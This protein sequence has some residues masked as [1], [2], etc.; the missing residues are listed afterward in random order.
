MEKIKRINFEKS[1]LNINP[2]F[3]G[4]ENRKRTC[5]LPKKKKISLNILL[6]GIH[7]QKHFRA[8]IFTTIKFV[9]PRD[10]K[11]NLLTK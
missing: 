9:F 2:D 6:K 3:E 5:I 1:T 8:F 11:R 10:N 7:V 4:S